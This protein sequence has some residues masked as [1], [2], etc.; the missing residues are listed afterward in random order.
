MRRGV[1]V[2]YETE[3]FSSGNVCNTLAANADFP[4]PEGPET[5]I[6]L[7]LW[8]LSL[9][10]LYLLPQFFDIRLDGNRVARDLHIPG[11]GQNRVG[12]ALQFL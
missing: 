10:V 11:F 4:A 7:P 12:L 5:I 1:L 9:N 3:N 2:V 8:S 6:R